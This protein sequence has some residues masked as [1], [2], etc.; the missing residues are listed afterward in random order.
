[1]LLSETGAPVGAGF[2]CPQMTQIVAEKS[3]FSFSVLFSVTICGNKTIFFTNHQ[4]PITNHQSPITNHQSNDRS[5]V[6][7]GIEDS[8]DAGCFACF[9]I[10]LEQYCRHVDIVFST[11]VLMGRL[12]EKAVRC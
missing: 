9:V 1:M 11:F 8:L 4:S 6:E 12:I 2:F 10:K 5:A 3:T 7:F